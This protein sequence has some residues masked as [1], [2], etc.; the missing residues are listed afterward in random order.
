[1]AAPII[2]LGVALLGALLLIPLGLPGTWAMVGAALVYR[3]AV[4]GGG[5]GTATIAGTAALALVGELLD[6]YMAARFTKRF[7]GSRRAAWGAVIGGFVGVGIGFPVPIA[8]PV[9]GGLLGSFLGA[10]VAEFEA[11]GRH[12]TATRVAVGALLARVAAAALKVT[13]GV[14]MAV[15]ILVSAAT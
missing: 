12:G 13:I 4:P 14:G 1:M 15:W 11:S 5:V 10:L 2:V 7:G 8:G 9:I 6:F 3:L